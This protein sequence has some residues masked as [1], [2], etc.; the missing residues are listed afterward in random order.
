MANAILSDAPVTTSQ[1]AGPALADGPSLYAPSIDYTDPATGNN[2]IIAAKLHIFK[3]GDSG[4]TWSEKDA[5]NAPSGYTGQITELYGAPALAPYFIIDTIVYFEY[6]VPGYT[7]PQIIP[8]ELSGDGTVLPSGAT[9]SNDTISINLL[10]YGSVV[11]ACTLVVDGIFGIS[12]DPASIAAPLA[13][14]LNAQ[15]IGLGITA[16]VLTFQVGGFLP[17]YS[18]IVGN[19]VH[20]SLDRMILTT[21]FTGSHWQIACEGNMLSPY[22]P[23]RAGEAALHVFGDFIDPITIFTVTGVD[24]NQNAIAIPKLFNTYGACLSNHVIYL[25]YVAP[26]STLAIAR[27]NTTTD[28]WM[29]PITGGPSLT[30]VPYDSFYAANLACSLVA[31]I[32]VRSTGAVVICYSVGHSEGQTSADIYYSHWVIYSAGAWG[33]VNLI[34][35]SYENCPNG[36]IID[37]SDNAIFFI[38]GVQNTTGTPPN[39]YIQSFVVLAN[40]ST[41]GPAAVDPSFTTAYAGIGVRD[42]PQTIPA[43][44][45]CAIVGTHL[46]I[47]ITYGSPSSY[48]VFMAE[49]SIT[50]LLAGGSWTTFHSP[51]YAAGYNQWF[52]AQ[53]VAYWNSQYRVFL[54]QTGSGSYNGTD[55]MGKIAMGS[56]NATGG[57]VDASW[58]TAATVVSL[59]SL[60]ALSAIGA[61]TIPYNVSAVNMQ[62]GYVGLLYTFYAFVASTTYGISPYYYTRFL[63]LGSMTASCNSPQSGSVNGPYA[64]TFTSTGGIPPLTWSVT[65]GSL[66]TGLTLNPAT[67]VVSGVP[68]ATGTFSFSLTVTDSLGNTASVSCSININT[69]FKATCNAYNSTVGTS[70]SQTI[71]VTGGV[72]PFT[73]SLQAGALPSGTTLNT[74]TGVI[75]GTLTSPGRFYYT[76][77]VV[78]STGAVAFATCS[79]QT[80]PSS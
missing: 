20:W 2:N 30:M 4:V 11:Q 25:A 47:G 43:P 62:G 23:A 69:V 68:T 3:S 24:A 65:S 27:Y 66:P 79:Q 31:E 54:C 71:G 6:P 36:S 41:V 74:S 50:S 16:D 73:F 70:Y 57:G 32:K 10:E 17:Y 72:S 77:K 53:S 39:N 26:D 64:H 38:N 19:V 56:G 61:S 59:N 45:Q 67:G 60:P 49:I 63:V 48:G 78:D 15:L 80:C 7:W 37:G 34:S 22:N 9:S 29:A 14:A 46:T 13:A 76:I 35:S 5:T 21:S 51:T 52:G 55:G 58:G 75:S 12:S 40:G 8:F 33:S 44:V 1:I 18:N 28:T 42:G